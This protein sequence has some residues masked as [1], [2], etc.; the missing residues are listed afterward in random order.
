[1]VALNEWA[2]VR[3]GQPNQPVQKNEGDDRVMLVPPGEY[4]VMLQ[5]HY[6]SDWLVWPERVRVEAGQQTVVSLSNTGSVVWLE[7]PEGVALNEWALVR[8]GQPDRPVQ[9]NEG[10]DRVMLVPPGEYEVLQQHYDSDWLVWPERVQVEAGRQVS[11]RPRLQ[12]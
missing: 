11:V 12:K 6:D 2:L 10:D 7:V 1:V 3:P 9:K 5:Q 4:E 8:P